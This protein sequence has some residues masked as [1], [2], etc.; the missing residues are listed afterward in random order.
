MNFCS[1]YFESS[2]QTVHNRIGRNQVDGSSRDLEKLE[3]LTYPTR[4]F[5]ASKGYFL[6]PGM[7]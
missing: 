6:D 7:L 5:G 4:L 1:L 2:A 3:A